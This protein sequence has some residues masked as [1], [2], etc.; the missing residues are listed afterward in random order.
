MPAKFRVIEYFT[1]LQMFLLHH[2]NKLPFVWMHTLKS[3]S[4]SLR[5]WRRDDVEDL[6][7]ITIILYCIQSPSLNR[8]TLAVFDGIEFLYN[9]KMAEDFSEEWF[10]EKISSNTKVNTCLT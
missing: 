9:L 3:W 7:Q 4:Q 10:L 6:L 2:L 8:K 1:S 5:S